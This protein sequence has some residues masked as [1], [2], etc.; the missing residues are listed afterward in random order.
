MTGGTHRGL[1]WRD[2]ERLLPLAFIAG[3]AAWLNA[4]LSVP[5]VIQAPGSDARVYFRAAEA[6]LAGGDPYAATVGPV[7]FASPPPTLFVLAPLVPLGETL[8]V[9]VILASGLVAAP[10]AIRR[11]GLPLWYLLFPPMFTSLWLGSLNVVMLA[12]L[13]TS[14][15][16]VATGLVALVKMYGLVPPL[17]LTRWR[18]L[19]GAAVVLLVTAPL[20]PWQAFLTSGAETAIEQTSGFTAWTTPVLIP[21]VLLALIVLGRE[22]SAWLTVPAL[23]PHGQSTYA[24]TALPAIHPILALALCWFHPLAAPFGIIAY[25]G[26]V[27]IGRVRS[28]RWSADRASGPQPSASPG[29]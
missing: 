21:A 1:A 6:W 22:R 20:L 26:W 12:L 16:A 14:S 17:I 28:R 5:A 15:G 24:V 3:D 9:L 4:R 11:M 27:A 29:S 18:G 25:G 23:W 2:L 13:V 10:W 8:A 7:T 19:A